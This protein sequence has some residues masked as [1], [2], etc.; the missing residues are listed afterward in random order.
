MIPSSSGEEL[1]DLF[2]STFLTK[3]GV[4]GVKSKEVQS[5][6][7]GAGQISSIHDGND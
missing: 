6:G 3:S 4:I 1:E 5:S 7:S 2:F